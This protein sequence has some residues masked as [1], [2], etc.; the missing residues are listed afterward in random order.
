[1]SSCISILW[2]GFTA[3]PRCHYGWEMVEQEFKRWSP[4]SQS[5]DSSERKWWP[6]LAFFAKSSKGI[7]TEEHPARSSAYRFIIF[8]PAN[9]GLRARYSCANYGATSLAGLAPAGTPAALSDL[10]LW[11]RQNCP[12]EA[13]CVW[14][15]PPFANSSLRP[16]PGQLQVVG[17]S[18]FVSLQTRA[19]CEASFGPCASSTSPG[20]LEAAQWT[21]SSHCLVRWLRHS[22]QHLLCFCKTQRALHMNDGEKGSKELLTRLQGCEI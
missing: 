7:K 9:T 10:A 15:L 13:P 22:W 21:H 5:M 20:L 18:P 6:K 17:S 2:S 14:K 3:A 16:H 8:P 12:S 11:R 1:M 4:C 19:G